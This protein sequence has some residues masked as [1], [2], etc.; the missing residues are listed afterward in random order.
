MD[1]N[2][3]FKKKEFIVTVMNRGEGKINETA[4]REINGG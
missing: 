1:R 3:T 4:G 2:D